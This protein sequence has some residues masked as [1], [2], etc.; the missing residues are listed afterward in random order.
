MAGLEG[1][2]NLEGV[3]GADGIRGEIP[4]APYEGLGRLLRVLGTG[5]GGSAL[6]GGSE[7]GWV[8]A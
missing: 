3:C 4:D 6:V 5:N 1:V 7:G 2:R 8:G